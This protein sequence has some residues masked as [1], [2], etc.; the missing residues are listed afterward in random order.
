MIGKQF[1][2]TSFRKILN[3][4]HNK[5]GARQI[6]TNMGSV[7]LDGL[8]KEFH[9]SRKLNPRLKRSVYHASLSVIPI[10]AM[11]D[12]RWMDIAE[13]Y[14]QGMGFGD[15]QYVV[16]RHHDTAH[17][18]IHMV[19]SRI[20]I[21]DGSIVSD[22]WDYRRSEVLIRQLEQAYDL[23][24]TEPS[25]DK[26]NRAHPSGE[27]SQQKRSGQPS[28]RQKLYPILNWATAHTD[29][30]PDYI[31]QVQSAGVEVRVTEQGI[32]YALE[33]VAFSGNKLGRDYSFVGLQKYRGVSYV[34]DRDDK[35]IAQLI[36][37]KHG[38]S[39]TAAFEV[40]ANEKAIAQFD[41]HEN[42]TLIVQL[43]RNCQQQNRAKQ[44][45]LEL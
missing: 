41:S 25:W 45:Q 36:G 15:S 14:L 29:T 6:G 26:P 19:A 24:S 42:K 27:F 8:V 32:S 38:S 16:Y 22:S 4:L 34:P 2:C 31:Q 7:T 33:G 1:K 12:D 43:D 11:D 39:Q 5:P 18:H 30:M 40:E 28:V 23:Q 44:V 13:D 10:E 21:G 37:T 9:E 35:A 3:Y 17:D 20:R